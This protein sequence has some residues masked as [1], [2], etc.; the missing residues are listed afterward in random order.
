MG[1]L[2]GGV[3]QFVRQSDG[4]LVQLKLFLNKEYARF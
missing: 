2:V 4:L 1:M 3:G